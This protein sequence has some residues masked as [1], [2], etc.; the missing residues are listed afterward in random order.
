[1]LKLTSLRPLENYFNLQQNQGFKEHYLRNAD[2]LDELL[3]PSNVNKARD[4]KRIFINLRSDYSSEG[5]EDLRDS[6]IKNDPILNRSIKTIANE[7]DDSSLSI[8]LLNRPTV[9]NDVCDFM[10]VESSAGQLNGIFS[11]HAGQTKYHISDTFNFEL[12][13]KKTSILFNSS[14]GGMIKLDAIIDS[15]F[16]SGS[17]MLS[18]LA[19]APKI[20]LVVGVVQFF[21]SVYPY[22]LFHEGNFSA[23]L[24]KTKNYIVTR[25]LPV[26]PRFFRNYLPSIII[27][28]STSMLTFISLY[29][30][31]FVTIY[32]PEVLKSPEAYVTFSQVVNSSARYYGS[33]CSSLSKHFLVGVWGELSD[34]FKELLKKIGL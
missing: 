10:K 3:V 27:G 11:K 15:C 19:M 33:L 29:V 14:E 26:L 23:L 1:M 7:V 5:M 12:I 28:A 6:F 34:N 16:N 2:V 21:H 24:T 32:K 20:L 31:G 22:C 18:F 17:E 4:M 8:L 25:S 30:T 9:I 13:V